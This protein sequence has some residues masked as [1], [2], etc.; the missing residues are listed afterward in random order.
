M[1]VDGP[2]K[3]I[4]KC[5]VYSTD[6][7]MTGSAAWSSEGSTMNRIREI[8]EAL[9][10]TGEELA[11]RVGTTSAQIYKL[12][13]GE[14]RLTADWMARIAEALG[15]S[16]ADLIQNAITAEFKDDVAPVDD[17]HP[18]VSSGMAS[19]GLHAYKVVGNSVI[20][21]GIKDGDTIT[22]DSS[23]EAV[24]KIETGDVALVQL[25]SPSVLVLRG[26]YVT[27]DV[28]LLLTVR[29]GANITISI[30]DPTVKP[31]ILG[32]VVR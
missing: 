1:S 5:G 10:M 22:V 17:L 15:C 16:P 25:A 28:T 32:V 6:W 13:R 8:R 19:R 26:A 23:Q 24:D 4:G 14:R 31:K 9:G 30:D 21:A 2:P 29:R 27:E 20:G 3:K 7:E 18:M 11:Q 12:E